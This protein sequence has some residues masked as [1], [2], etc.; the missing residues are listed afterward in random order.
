MLRSRALMTCPELVAGICVL[1]PVGSWKL[2][3][4]WPLIQVGSWGRVGMDVAAMP[5]WHGRSCHVEVGS[6][7]C[8]GMHTAC[9]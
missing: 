2:S 6:W 3:S 1:F 4:T 7:G 9:M 5:R 8:V